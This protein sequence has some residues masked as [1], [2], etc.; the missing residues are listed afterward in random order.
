MLQVLGCIILCEIIAI[1]LNPLPKWAY[2]AQKNT[3]IEERKETA[4]Y[5][6]D[7]FFKKKKENDKG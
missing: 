6:I 7:S 5:I 1:P 2:E 4:D 3:R